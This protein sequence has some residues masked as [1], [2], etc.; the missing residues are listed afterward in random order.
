MHE[1]SIVDAL[2]E[3]VR[4][5]VERSGHRGRVSRLELAIG[6]FSGVNVE[7]LRFAFQMLA[8]GTLVESAD[9]LIAEPKALCCCR[10]CKARTE[11]ADLVA[12][13]PACGGDDVWLEGGQELV[14]RTID[15]VEPE[16]A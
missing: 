9:L 5:E 16:E 14:L 8:P 13:C 4:Q 12:S 7:C 1:V 10:Q 6:P 11:I 15:L 2:I 3:R